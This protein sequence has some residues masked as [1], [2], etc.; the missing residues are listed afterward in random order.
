MNFERDTVVAIRTCPIS[1]GTCLGFVLL[2]SLLVGWKVLA[3]R[4]EEKETKRI[5]AR[6]RGEVKMGETF[7]YA[8]GPGFCFRLDPNPHGWTIVI[9]DERGTQDISRLT[10]PFHFVPNPR[11]IEGWHFRNADN[12]G[13]NEAG[14]KNVNAPGIARDFI[15]SPEVGK[16]IDGPMAEGKPT[17]EEIKRVRQF[18]RGELRIL[19]YRL[20]DLESGKQ[21]RFEWVRF[22]VDLSWPQ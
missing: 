1:R 6:I 13:P 7:E 10:P 12:S 8:F 20:T 5:H 18:G 11:E 21:A 17:A 4:T 9:K 19:D 2:L 15:F 14:E 3:A 16:S 22:E